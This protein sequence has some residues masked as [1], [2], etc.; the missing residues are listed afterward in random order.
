MYMVGEDVQEDEQKRV[1]H[2]EEAAIAGHPDARYNLGVT[3][4]I[5][6]RIERR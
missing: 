4:W 5:N 6:D 1:Y 3:E 2:M